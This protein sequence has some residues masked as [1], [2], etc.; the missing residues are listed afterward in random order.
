MADY[1]TVMAMTVSGFLACLALAPVAVAQSYTVGNR[2]L[3]RVSQGVL[4]QYWL[5]NPDKAPTTLNARLRSFN[6]ALSRFRT[7]EV[8]WQRESHLPAPEGKPRPFN[9]DA[10]GLPQN[11]ES[12]AICDPRKNIILGATND[13]R[14]LID[15]QGNF[16]GWHLSVD[17]GKTV[18]NEGLLP[19]VMIAGSP[20]PSRSDPVVTVSDDC[21]LFAASLNYDPINSF[22][23]PNGVGVYRSDTETLATCLGGSEP[24]CWP[25]RQ[26]I[27]E[28]EP[29][30]F[31]DKPWFDVGVSGTQKVVW[32]AYTDVTLD[33]SAPLGFTRSSIKAV[34]CS[35]D[36]SSCTD[37][38]LISD[39]DLDV[40]FSDVTIGYDGRTYIT[41]SEIQGE[42]EGTAQTFIHKLRIAPAGSSDFGPERIIHVE[43]LAIPFGG[44]LNAN[45][46]R[47]ATY[48]KHEV[49]RVNGVPRIFVVWDACSTRPLGVICEEAQIKLKYSDDDG[50]S[51][52]P[53][54]VLSINGN[55]YF[56]TI[57]NNR[58]GRLALAWFTNRFDPQFQ[59]RQDVEFLA[60]D[61]YGV[62]PLRRQRLT[63]VSNEPEADALLGGGFIGDYIEITA[64]KDI[65]YV[66]YNANYRP[67][68]LLGEGF[69][70][71]QQDNF[72]AKVRLYGVRQDALE[73]APNE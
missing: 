31:L 27:A 21:T 43:K 16:I 15:P 68:P 5:A 55:N 29:N 65:A 58:A 11:E 41:W 71:P 35:T 59:N 3:T 57:A 39:D 62:K 40:Q 1:R 2:L 51:W 4:T 33:A 17:G 66:H 20:V 56:P 23:N 63:R 8:V 22:G 53:E 14:G 32:V 38:I 26:A 61:A 67:I 60:L 30:H 9:L 42:L 69:P 64:V 10:T 47:I 45:D 34:R 46:F 28:S 36:L 19:P 70:I 12:I 13:Y 50:I 73:D 25:T 18:K 52:S 37:P 7:G 72:L 49:T 54:K 6:S 48:T 44:S 24:S